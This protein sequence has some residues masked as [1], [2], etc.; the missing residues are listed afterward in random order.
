MHRG[1]LL[2]GTLLLAVSIPRTVMAGAGTSPGAER[3][4]VAHR[5]RVVH[6]PVGLVIGSTPPEGWSHLVIKS[7]PRL[8]SGD[9]GSLPR[10]AARTASL[11][12]TVILA[13][14]GQL[15]NQPGRRVLRRVGLGLC[16]PDQRGR[17]VVVMPGRDTEAGVSLGLTDR[18]VL[19]AAED[20]LSR[21]K[22]AAATP[23]FALYRAPAVLA[24]RGTHHEIVVCYAFL[25]VPGD[26]DLRTLVWMQEKAQAEAPA[27]K[28]AVELAPNLVYECPLDVRAKR[29]LGAI[30]VSWSFAM[31]GLPPG[32]PREV[33]GTA[34]RLIATVGREPINAVLLERSLRQATSVR[35]NASRLPSH[36]HLGARALTAESGLVRSERTSI[37]RSGHPGTSPSAR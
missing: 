22:L 12:R 2:A 37:S 21:G 9:L 29:L 5:P 6:L 34:A 1:F 10:S 7:L 4:P 8:G 15:P 32:R 27:Q 16:V 31:T 18:L 11:F 14:V 17:D 35:V 19:D 20:Q 28:R 30:P 23:T 33:S 3:E 24:V 13:D 36:A 25:V 26:G